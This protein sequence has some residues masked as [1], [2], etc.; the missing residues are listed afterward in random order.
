MFSF[1][2][3]FRKS[4]QGYRYLRLVPIIYIFLG[5]A[6]KSKFDRITEIKQNIPQQISNGKDSLRCLQCGVKTYK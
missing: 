1:L 5:H 4:V 6:V 2:V 3:P